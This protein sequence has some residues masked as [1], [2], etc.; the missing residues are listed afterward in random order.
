[1][2]TVEEVKALLEN[3]NYL[4]LQVKSL[5][6]QYEDYDRLIAETGG[7]RG[8]SQDGLPHGNNKSDPVAEVV[9]NAEK[10]KLRYSEKL[11]DRLAAAEKIEKMLDVVGE[12]E[13]FIL[14]SIYVDKLNIYRIA[15]ELHT[16]EATVYRRK[17][18]AI[19]KIFE[20]MKN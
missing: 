2:E 7:I 15:K 13:Q 5:K 6:K 17:D 8:I 19:K 9:L 20:K 4:L 3:Y 12:D 1:M 10:M 18:A 14:R 11:N 16:S